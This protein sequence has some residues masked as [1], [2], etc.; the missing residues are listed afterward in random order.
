[1]SNEN[2]FQ[3]E[4]L[5]VGVEIWD[6]EVG[7]KVDAVARIE[8]TEDDEI[9]L[10]IQRVDAVGMPIVYTSLTASREISAQLAAR[11]A[12]EWSEA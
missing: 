8:R 2:E 4:P 1:M 10:V 12:E 6:D 5:K 9:A 11:A 3:G 7:G